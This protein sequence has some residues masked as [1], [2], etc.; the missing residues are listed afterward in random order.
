VGQ[1]V[2]R[3]DHSQ[4]LQEA[5]AERGGEG[6]ALEGSLPELNL[7]AHDGGGVVGQEAPEDLEPLG[8]EG[9]AGLEYV[10]QVSVAERV[11]GFLDVEEGGVG[12]SVVAGDLLEDGGLLMAGSPRGKPGLCLVEQGAGGRFRDFSWVT[13]KS[14]SMPSSTIPLRTHQDEVQRLITRRGGRCGG[15]PSP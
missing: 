13:R 15:Q 12:D 14:Y 11:E 3:E 7:A 10:K 2:V 1:D 9:E 5:E 4:V 8:V 6:G